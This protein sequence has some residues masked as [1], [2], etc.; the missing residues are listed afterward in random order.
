[1]YEKPRADVK[2][3][4]GSTETFKRPSKHFLYFIYASK[5]YVSTHVRIKGQGKSNLRPSKLLE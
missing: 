3:A 5:I 1:M 4:R 2:V